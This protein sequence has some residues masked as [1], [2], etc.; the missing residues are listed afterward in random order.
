MY[1]H[2]TYTPPSRGVARG[3][4]KDPTDDPAELLVDGTCERGG[5]QRA[6]PQETEERSPDECCRT[7]L[8]PQLKALYWEIGSSGHR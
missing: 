6:P 2:D 5:V 3:G 8:L 4:A 1:W 7:V